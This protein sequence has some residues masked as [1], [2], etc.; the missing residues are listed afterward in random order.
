MKTKT[1]AIIAVGLL[2][3]SPFIAYEA[4]LFWAY[5]FNPD[6]NK[7]NPCL[8][9]GGKWDYENWVCIPGDEQGM[10]KKASNKPVCWMAMQP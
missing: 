6:Y 7:I 1:K 8:G 10:N 5:D 4:F 2:I 3:L 9:A